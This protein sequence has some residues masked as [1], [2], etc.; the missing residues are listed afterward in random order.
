MHNNHP[1]IIQTMLSPETVIA[2]T[3]KWITDVVVGCNFCP[4]AA[5]EVNRESIYYEVVEDGHLKT[6]LETLARAFTRMDSEAGVET[7]FLI[8]PHSF[9][10]FD[11]Y[12][13]LVEVSEKLL[14]KSG[15]EGVYQIASFHP[16]Y[17]FAGAAKSDPANYT[18]RSP[19]PMLQLLR[20]ESLT[21]A[22]DRYPDTATI[23]EHNIAFARKKG[24]K[25]MQE[26]REGCMK[27]NA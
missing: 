25:Q 13:Q 2:Q 18:N 7:L 4:F 8:M 14:E 23:P 5:R 1:Q 27:G 6:V 3:K 19:H 17:L 20:E 26:L 16:E 21:A 22:I 15:Y 24:L 9:A 11:A 12:L 10:S